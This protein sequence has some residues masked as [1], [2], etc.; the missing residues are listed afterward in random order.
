MELDHIVHFTKTSPLE[1]RDY[2]KD[3]GFHAV[4]GGSHKNW[5]TRNAL[6]YGRDYYIEWLTVENEDIAESSPHPLV[7]HLRYD[8]Q[9]YG[10]ICL[11]SG[12]LEELAMQ[13]GK[14]G[15][16][17][18]GVLDAERQT[19]SGET[20][21]WKMLFIEQDISGDLPL[22]FFIEWEEADDRRFENLKANGA[23]RE[24]N[25]QLTMDTLVFS[26]NDPAKR[27]K[28][29]KS[30]LD[31]TLELGNC[32]IA[33]QKGEGA[34]RLSE[35]RFASGERQIIFEKGAYLVP[36]FE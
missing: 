9:G 22:P 27:E 33:F 8:Q 17:T 23:I 7:E 14:K 20:I 13:L 2:W 6:M 16:P 31:D 1:S 35:V 5:G 3:T 24:E 30:L 26:V 32:R 28:Q 18:G 21:R 36:R 11:R 25:E 4:I 29:W 19:E 15:I 12:N 10:T 34:E